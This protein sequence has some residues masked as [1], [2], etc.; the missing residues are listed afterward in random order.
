MK[1]VLAHLEDAGYTI[2]DAVKRITYCGL[3]T[4]VYC[5]GD[6]VIRKSSSH[7]WPTEESAM[8]PTFSYEKALSV[9]KIQRNKLL[10]RDTQI[11]L[12]SSKVA[13]LQKENAELRQ[14]NKL[15]QEHIAS[16]EEKREN[17][18]KALVCLHAYIYKKLDLFEAKVVELAAEKEALIEQV[19]DLQYLLNKRG[20]HVRCSRV[21]WP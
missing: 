20:V 3:S 8:L 2:P 11:S 4:Q 6:G 12:L 18:R 5:L 7:M 15:Q 13:A 10:D 1:L 17:I 16:H 14:S 21:P 19:S 9:T